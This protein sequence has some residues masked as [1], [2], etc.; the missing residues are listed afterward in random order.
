MLVIAHRG[1]C[2]E[3]TENSMGAFT[4][5]IEAGADR[6]EFDIQCSADH[7]IF[8]FHDRTT[9]RLTHKPIV[10]AHA[11]AATIKSLRLPNGETIPTL[12]EVFQAF[13]GQVEFNIELKD[14]H[15]RIVDQLILLIEQCQTRSRIIVSSFQHDLIEY[16]AQKAP[17]LERALLFDKRH[18]LRFLRRLEATMQRAQ[19]NI[20]HP[21]AR[22]ISKKLMACARRNQWEVYP[23]ISIKQEPRF[24]KL[25]DDLKELGVDGLCTNFPRRMHAWRQS[26]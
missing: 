18:S 8:V 15:P 1:A 23:Y 9:K 3:T 14:H 12:R 7:E 25:W 26:T 24:P 17:G 5:A 16:L 6:I 20:L 21:D 2:D 13:D 22:F 11:D 19:A 4:R 10:L